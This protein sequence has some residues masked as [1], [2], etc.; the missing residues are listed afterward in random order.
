MLIMA[1]VIEEMIQKKKKMK[2]IPMDRES[3]VKHN[4]N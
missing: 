4:E 2:V 3:V 1:V